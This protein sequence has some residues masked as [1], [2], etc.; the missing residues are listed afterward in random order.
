MDV[1]SLETLKAAVDHLKDAV[2]TEVLPR[3]QT[4]IDQSMTNLVG[5]AATLIDKTFNRA[6]ALV[7]ATINKISGLTVTAVVAQK[8]VGQA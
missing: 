3:A 7:E 6:E 2:M 5:Q 1:E 4:L 8:K